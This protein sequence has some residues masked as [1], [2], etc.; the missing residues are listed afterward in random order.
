MPS[1]LSPVEPQV[2][3]NLAPHFARNSWHVTARPLRLT[4]YPDLL[5]IVEQ[6]ACKWPSLTFVVAV[7]LWIN[8]GHTCWPHVHLI[9]TA[10]QSQAL[11]I[12]GEMKGQGMDV[13]PVPVDNE[14]HARQ[15]C[16]R[17]TNKH[18]GTTYYRRIGVPEPE[19]EQAPVEHL[20]ECIQVPVF[21]LFV[22]WLVA[23]IGIWEREKERKSDPVNIRSP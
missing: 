23:V 12:A 1:Y 9:V 19:P 20:P 18:G 10:T 11:A 14:H 2:A 6:V 5:S 13:L 7:E 16:G 4:N 8:K 17:Y 15:L 21:Q 22:T 3:P